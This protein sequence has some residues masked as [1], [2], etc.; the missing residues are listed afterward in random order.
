MISN[1]PLCPHCHS[2]RTSVHTLIPKSN[3]DF[4]AIIQCDGCNRKFVVPYI[5]EDTY[6]FMDDIDPVRLTAQI[7]K[8]MA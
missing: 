4:D 7:M 6:A 2:L 1:I 3:G 8:G 5:V